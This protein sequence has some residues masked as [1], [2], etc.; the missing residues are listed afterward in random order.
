MRTIATSMLVAMA[1][2][3]VVT[4]ILAERWPWLLYVKAFAEASMVGGLADWFAVTALFRHPL[5][6]PIPHT[7][8]IPRNKDRIGDTLGAFLRQNFLTPRVVARRLR[9][10]DIA[11]AVGRWLA[12]PRGDSRVTG[13]F[14]KVVKQTVEALDNEAI[15]GLIRTTVAQRLRA[16]E[17]SPILGSALEA[18]VEGGRHE[19]VLD[20]A[21]QWA[22]RTLDANE[23]RIR[24]AV[25]D[26]AGWFVR[27]FSIDERISDNIVSAIRKLLYEV[28]ADPYH[29]IRQR[30]SQGLADFA[31]DLK[32][33]PETRAKAEAIKNELL[34]HPQIG[35]YLG[36]LWTSL[37]A[38]LTRSVG[39][40]NST[41]S[42]QLG[43]ATRRLGETLQG[44]ARLRA[45]LNLHAR[46]AIVGIVADYGE[47]ITRLVSD[48]IRTW[49][50]G[51]VTTR[52]EAAVGKDLQY[53]RING[54]LIGGLVGLTIY[55]LSTAIGCPAL[56]RR[57]VAG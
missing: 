37:K 49:D 52:V 2:L 5:G 18:A 15:G 34:E 19:P 57:V 24:D 40:P 33:M 27:T 55:A 30:V 53:I 23:D 9:G 8:I 6:L 39:D 16:M 25:S 32:H 11:A 13:G 22:S 44:D 7:A 3:F 43:E 1:A 54:T 41:L 56:G 29:P 21:L 35:D 12:A 17:V 47:E 26:R 28:A 36:G 31:F 46:R 14:S 10:F 51:T 42:I 20:S 45:A 38:S 4:T 50:A 48:T